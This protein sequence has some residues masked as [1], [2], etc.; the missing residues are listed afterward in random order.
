MMM[1]SFVLKVKPHMLISFP[2]VSLC[3]LSSC[4]NIHKDMC[5][6]LIYIYMHILHVSVTLRDIHSTHPPFQFQHATFDS[7]HLSHN[8][9]AYIPPERKT[10]RI[11]ALHLDTAPNASF[12]LLIPTCWNLK[13]LVNR[14]TPNANRHGPNVSRWNIVYIGRQGLGLNWA[15]RF[16]VVCV[17][18]VCVGYPT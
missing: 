2:G 17:I 15:C 3:Y 16:H 7:R 18:F 9:L 10:I 12:V 1:S 5:L 8:T 4:V 13:S 11:W 14:R 6:L